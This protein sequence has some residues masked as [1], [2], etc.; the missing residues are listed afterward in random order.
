MMERNAGNEKRKG[1]ELIRC[2][3]CAHFNYFDNAEGHNS[4]HALGKCEAE[5]WD[6]NRGQWP[7]FLHHCKNVKKKD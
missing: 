2:A 3:M 6:G 5:P 1:N 7:M 4:P